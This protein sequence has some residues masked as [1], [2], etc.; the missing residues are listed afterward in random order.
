VKAK[1]PMRLITLSTW[2][3]KRMER[4]LPQAVEKIREVIQ[5]RRKTLDS[6]DTDG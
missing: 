1:T 2:D 3:M 6:K 4:D 5:E